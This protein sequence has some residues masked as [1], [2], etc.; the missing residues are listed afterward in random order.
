MSPKVETKKEEA[1]KVESKKKKLES[2]S[3][4]NNFFFNA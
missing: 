2:L 1:P 4:K 3:E